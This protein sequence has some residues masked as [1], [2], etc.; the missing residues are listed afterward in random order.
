VIRVL[1]A[2]DSATVREYLAWLLDGDPGLEVVGTARDGV[3][4]VEQA[5]RLKPDVLLM[6]VHMPRLNGYEATRQIMERAPAPI[7]MI[8]AS[9][10]RDEVAMT[11][12]ALEAGA[13]T[14]LGKPAGPD[15]PRHAE[16]A[17]RIRETVRLMSEVKVVRRWPRREPPP[18]RA[19]LALPGRRIR[20]VAVGAS[21]GGPPVVAQIL[22]AL[23]RD[24]GASVLLV[25]H[26]ASGFSAGLAE[27]LDQVAP[28]PVKLAERGEPAR[29]GSVYVAP[30]GWQMGITTQGR[31]HLSREPAEDGF[32]PSASSLFESVAASYGR[33]GMGVLLTGMGR[34]G[35]SGLRRLRQAGG[36]TIAQDE[37]TS[38]VFGMP[39]EAIRLGAADHVLAPDQIADAIRALAGKRDE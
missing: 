11:F 16:A 9:L 14:V 25:Q 7:V 28:L 29:P 38:A 27:W 3:E 35:A 4:A 6:D 24:L 22:K 21:T 1:L 30:E 15:D 12:A 19:P 23:P 18:P 37:A 31:I 13:L 36:L 32:C 8:S 5:E 26:I 10:E 17:R 20:L 33:S 2:E 34:D 39:G